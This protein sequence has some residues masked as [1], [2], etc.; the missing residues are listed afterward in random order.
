M[1]EKFPRVL[2]EEF[3]KSDKESWKQQLDQFTA[4]TNY[5]DLVWRPARDMDIEP[6]YTRQEW[7]DEH[8]GFLNGTRAF[9][10]KMCEN[11]AYSKFSN[12]E[13][14]QANILK[15]IQMGADGV[16]L[17]LAGQGGVLPSFLEGID[18]A[19]LSITLVDPGD[20]GY[21]M[22][23][24][25]S[26]AQSYPSLKGGLYYSGVTQ[27]LDHSKG[28][29][30]LAGLMSRNP[31]LMD[32]KLLGIRGPN[33]PIF[34]SNPARELA[35][36]MG[37]SVA[38]M[39]ALD[40]LGCSYSQSFPSL[41]MEVR[42][43]DSFF[44]EI[45]KIRA[46]RFLVQKVGELLGL[47]PALTSAFRIHAHIESPTDSI[48]SPLITT[49]TRAISARLGGADSVCIRCDSG[50][51]QVDWAAFQIPTVLKYESDFSDLA[52][53]CFGSYYIDKVTGLVAQRAWEEFQSIERSG[54]IIE[55]LKYHPDYPDA[56]ET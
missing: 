6:L 34:G 28:L 51:S 29:D 35:F 44:L 41:E 5:S 16:L 39:E 21:W 23:P 49:A 46:L 33:R 40:S 47:G 15:K 14:T 53:P 38:H 10:P 13:T 18:L 48:V 12:Q 55:F 25:T 19:M 56:D 27:L 50:T 52:D 8:Y 1:L 43:G 37:L 42:I 7:A 2:F 45:G 3:R 26:M 32:F 17:D 4:P 31:G 30:E 54:G 9:F 24:L 36:I 20:P 11:R 22:D